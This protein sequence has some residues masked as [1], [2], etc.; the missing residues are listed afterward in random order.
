MRA[1]VKA[2]LANRL[3]NNRAH[4]QK[5]MLYTCLGILI[6]IGVALILRKL[7]LAQIH[8]ERVLD[9]PVQGTVAHL[10]DESCYDE[11]GELVC[12]LPEIEYHA[13]D[14][15][16][17]TEV[18]TLVC[19]L[20][21]GPDHTHDDGCYDIEYEL[22]CDRP[23]I[24]EEHV[25]GPGCF[26]TITIDDDSETPDGMRSGTTT[27]HSG[28]VKM[29]C[30]GKTARVTIDAPAGAGIPDGSTAQVTELAEG[31]D[32]YEAHQEMA[33]EALSVDDATLARFFDVTILNPEGE[34][35]Q[36]QAPVRVKIQLTNAPTDGTPPVAVH[37]GDNDENDGKT[38]APDIIPTELNNK[39]AAFDAKSFSVYG[40]V[41]TV[42]FHWAD[43]ELKMPGGGFV[44]L[45]KLVGALG[46]GDDD[47]ENDPELYDA[48]PTAINASD[49]INSEQDDVE[50][51]DAE[52]DGEYADETSEDVQAD[53]EVKRFVDDV[54]RV[55]FSNSDLVWIGRIEE[56][57]T[58]GDIKE[59]NDLDV[60]YSAE[61][62]EEQIDEINNSVIESGD[63]V[64]ISM[65]PFSS[66]EVL[67]ITMKDGKQFTVGVT[68]DSY[69]GTAITDLNGKTGVLVNL[70]NNNALQDSAHS[71]SG[72]LKA[73]GTSYNTN[74]HRITTT[75]PYDSLTEWTFTQVQGTQDQYYIK[76]PNGYLRINYGGETGLTVGSERQA[77][78]V[79]QQNGTIRIKRTDNNS[80][81]NNT[82]NATGNG[83]GVYGSNWM[84]NPGEWFTF[85]EVSDVNGYIALNPM[86][87]NGVLSGRNITSTHYKNMTIDGYNV[88]PTINS[89]LNLDRSRIYIPVAYNNDDGTATIT[90]PSNDQ[91]GGFRV[92]D[93]EGDSVSHSI[94]Q[95]NDKYQ[96]VLRGW[97]NIADGSYYD[98]T[99]GPATATVS[100][101]KLDVFYADWAP[102]P[103]NYNHTIANPI[104]TADTS[105]FVSIGMWDYNELYNLKYSTPYKVDDD[106]GKYEPR[107]SLQSEEWYVNR[108]GDPNVL[109]VDNTD[110]GNA[111]QY[112]TLGDAQGRGG[113]NQWS[114]Y[115]GNQPRSGIVGAWGQETSGRVLQ[116]LFDTSNTPGSGV[117]YLGQSN[118]LFTYDDD[119][120][121]YSY[122]SDENGAVYNQNEHRFYVADAPRMHEAYVWPDPDTPRTGF[123]PY[124]DYDGTINYRNGTTNY[125]FGMKMEMNFWLADD[126]GTQGANPVGRYHDDTVFTFRGD[127]DVWVFVDDKLAL[128][129]GG[130]HEAL[131]GS[132]NFSTG[133]ISVQINGQGGTQTW[134]LADM[135]IRA[136]AHTLSFYYVERG[137]NASNCEIKFNLTPRWIQPPVDISTAKAT[138][139]WSEHTPE[140]KKQSLQ[141]NLKSGNDVIDT[142]G[143][144]DGTEESGTWTYVWEGLD[145]SK[146]YSVEEIPDPAFVTMVTPQINDE[147]TYEYW[148]PAYYDDATS[149]SDGA[150]LGNGR[151]PDGRVLDFNGDSVAATIEYDVVRK[152]SVT[153]SMVWTVTGY[154]PQVMH[155]YLKNDSGNYL[156]IKNGSTFELVTSQSDASYFYVG[157]TGDLNDANSSHRLRIGDNGDI[158]I[159]DKLG[160]EYAGIESA[161]R[162]HV[163][164]YR[165]IKSKTFD[166]VFAN[167]IKTNITVDKVDKN[168][169]DSIGGATF[170]LLKGQENVDL[171]TLTITALADDSTITP[172]DYDY[173]GTTIK[174]VTIP[175]GGIRIENLENG[176]YT[177][178]EMVPPDGYVISG[179]GITF[180]TEDGIVKNADNSAHQDVA[181]GITFKAE[182]EPGSALP[183]A[184]GPGTTLYLALGTLCIAF[185]SAYLLRKRVRA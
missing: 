103:E 172:E 111:W 32:E 31:T 5:R 88:D 176:T 27:D 33:L 3:L 104:D 78:Q 184:G 108:S 91:L 175:E 182:N 150:V 131:N 117:T 46:L 47:L 35:I 79:Q 171:T 101:D 177:L 81:V 55:E 49:L 20:E 93:A 51:Y 82:A 147:G 181:E 53:E 76:S 75:N 168:S 124:N 22:T 100:R 60:Q 119:R 116:D 29:I 86:N 43:Y 121:L 109:F 132:I 38:P 155:F 136:G 84:E 178:R 148:A 50:E 134:N 9:C 23:E 94:I 19:G 57:S 112:G 13:H 70:R 118:Y 59:Y 14:E 45:E 154:D 99:E 28:G 153:D 135:G 165:S 105:S 26:Q 102:A 87:E 30:E 36:P 180:I 174:V 73:A 34:E 44:S 142:V 64:L 1:T 166:Y 62:T 149:F 56:D 11:D 157:P 71:E 128:D 21:E 167:A 179:D 72:R 114:N 68:D 61:L 42:D 173:H 77:L 160:S 139:T 113:T 12:P 80:A 17:Y 6:C 133:V 110:S 146:E 18:R 40:V 67:T 85:F 127:D 96:W 54:E 129:I 8:T 89:D 151:N 63:W 69:T 65:K 95:G 120:K 48:V 24:T 2:R 126:P 41:Y 10:H 98:V 92:S 144:N 106:S 169:G 39:T 170:G 143:Y 58:V 90:L 183:H 107:D 158:V 156:S 74:T 97:V 162:V 130:I 125:W 123:L 163:Y 52:D 115:S 15:E 7:A 159:G 122:D 138:K 141:F 25:H 66:N 16:C 185:A 164:E 83:Y 37:F 137:A 152:E 4:E 145:P 161:D 140:D